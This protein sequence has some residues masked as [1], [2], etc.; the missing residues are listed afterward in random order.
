[1]TLLSIEDLAIDAGPL[2]LVDGVTLDVAPGEV[3]AL[4]GESGS[5]KSL[6]ALAVMGLLGEGLTVGRGRVVF[7]DTDL[8]ALPD[9]ELRNLRGADLAMIFQEPVSSL[10][11]LVPVGA[12][13]AESL[14]V[15]DRA[16][17]VEAMKQAIDMLRRVG[18]PEPARRAM[19]LPTELSGGMCQRVMIAAALISKPRLLIADEPTTALDVTIQAQIL[20]LMR[21]LA[22]EVGTAILL[23]THDMGVVAELADRV[24]VMYGGRV[25]EQA[26]V[27]PLFASPRHP[28]TRMLLRTIPR[29]D[30]PPKGELFAIKGNVPS[31]RDWPEGCRFR[32]RCDRATDACTARPIL[33]DGPH[34]IACFHPV[35]GM[36]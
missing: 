36:E 26:P 23:I 9:S 20:A 4:V 29:L 15:H 21:D 12:Q 16:S 30:E 22:A 33:T 7:D 18:I 35:E 27:D 2:S 6:T 25:V 14:F 28:Y 5:G 19:Q 11:P 10:N 34:R 32:T 13:V 31:P 1:M 3:V 17:P 8:T 24:C